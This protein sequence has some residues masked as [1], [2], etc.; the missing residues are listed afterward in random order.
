LAERWLEY[1]A[2]FAPLRLDIAR[3]HEKK[4]KGDLV[5]LHR[6]LF[7]KYGK[8]RAIK[9]AARREGFLI[10]PS[11]KDS[12]VPGNRGMFCSM[13]VA[14]CYQVAGLQELVECP[15]KGVLVSDKKMTPAEMKK[16]EEEAL[17]FSKEHP[18]WVGDLKQIDL[19]DF[20]WYIG[21]LNEFD[22]YKLETGNTKF[23]GA[24]KNSPQLT[25]ATFRPSLEFWKG[26]MLIFQCPWFK[27]IT[28]GMML[29][30][31]VIMPGGLLECLE[32]D[33]KDWEVMGVLTG[34]RAFSE[35]T[36]EKL[37]RLKLQQAKIKKLFK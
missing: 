28:K 32:D 7:Q 23:K 27:Y 9:Y 36:E 20:K 17:I 16:Y 14:L 3:D 12:R 30:A 5:K 10:Y 18:G 35:T 33:K 11:E 24:Q 22:P 21:Q 6:E 29:D 37:E 19:Q 15:P 34:E 13:F 31:K 1:P 25:Y 26:E 4:H 8:Y 2:P